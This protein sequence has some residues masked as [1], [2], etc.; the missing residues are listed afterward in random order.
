MLDWENTEDKPYQLTTHLFLETV[1]RPFIS[2]TDQLSVIEFQNSSLT[3]FTLV[4]FLLGYLLFSSKTFYHFGLVGP[5]EGLN[6]SKWT[7]RILY[8][9]MGRRL[10]FNRRKLY[11]LNFS[12]MIISTLYSILNKFYSKSE[13]FQQYICC[14]FAEMFTMQNLQMNYIPASLITT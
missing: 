5:W 4:T 13:R 3:N 9:I 2:P 6:K 14:N 11:F 10:L 12:L 1:T 7:D 8:S